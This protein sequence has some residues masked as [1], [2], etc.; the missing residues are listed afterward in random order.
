M[1]AAPHVAASMD[2]PPAPVPHLSW[3]CVGGFSLVWGISGEDA[4]AGL[5]ALWKTLSP[6]LLVAVRESGSSHEG[7]QS[8]KNRREADRQAAR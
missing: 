1:S 8:A 3:S 6:I 4:R 5:G 2:P 7:F